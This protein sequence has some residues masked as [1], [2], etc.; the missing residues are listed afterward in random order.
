MTHLLYLYNFVRDSELSIKN[1][2]RIEGSIHAFYIQFICVPIISKVICCHCR[3]SK[4][5]MGVEN[6][7]CVLSLSIFSHP[8]RYMYINYSIIIPKIYFSYNIIQKL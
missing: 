6:Q 5:E 8:T 2:V 3:S 1:K 7:I 4:K